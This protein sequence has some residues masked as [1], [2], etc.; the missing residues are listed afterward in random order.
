MAAS[1]TPRTYALYHYT[2]SMAAAVIFCILFLLSTILHFVQM[3]KTK[4][5]FLIAFFL[6]GLFEFMG[7]AARASSAASEPGHYRLMPFIIQSTYILLA[8]ALFAATIYMVLGRVVRLTDG[9]AHSIIKQRWLTMTFLGG[10]V[11]CFMLQSAGGGL[12]AKDMTSP[13]SAGAQMG[14]NIILAGLLLQ[15][16]WFIFFVAVA[17]LFHYRMSLHPTTRA[18]QPEIR[19]QQYLRSLY[20]V[21]GLIMIRSRFRLIEYSQGYDGYLLSHEVFFYVFDALLMLGVMV[22]MNWQHP[23]EISLLLKGKEPHVDGFTLIVNTIHPKR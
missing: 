14:K 3:F 11:F 16:L 23:S 17:A 15:L 13:G 20:V 6:G 2:P 19:W 10:D 12:L 5:W 21:S 8:P 22:W 1:D 9:E 7:Y 18:Q 4:A